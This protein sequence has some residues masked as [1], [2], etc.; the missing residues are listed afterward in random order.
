MHWPIWIGGPIVS[1]MNLIRTYLYLGAQ[2]LMH[3][4]LFLHSQGSGYKSRHIKRKPKR[5]KHKKTSK[6]SKKK[7]IYK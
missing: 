5:R 6:R 4:V 1:L 3:L 2:V 7:K